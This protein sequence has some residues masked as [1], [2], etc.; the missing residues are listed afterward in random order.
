VIKSLPEW[1]ACQV[2]SWLVGIV[3]DIETYKS[4]SP[5]RGETA[6]LIP[7]LGSLGAYE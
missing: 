6:K 1:D 5:V 7:M 2:K 3:G 4:G